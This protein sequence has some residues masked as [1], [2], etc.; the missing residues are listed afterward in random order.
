[1]VTSSCRSSIIIVALCYSVDLLIMEL[2]CIEVHA[3]FR[4]TGHWTIVHR[5]IGHKNDCSKDYLLVTCS[6][7]IDPLNKRYHGYPNNLSVIPS[8]VLGTR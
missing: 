6:N 5:T 4:T 7:I 2:T 3:D 8:T 1:M